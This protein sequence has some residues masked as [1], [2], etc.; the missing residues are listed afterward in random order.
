MKIS[1][2]FRV[3]WLAALILLTANP[4][5]ARSWTRA[6]DKKQLTAAFAGLEDGKILLKLP[7]GRTV[8]APLELFTPADQEAAKRFAIL[9]DDIQVLKAAKTIDTMLAKQLAKAGFKG[10]NPELPDDLFVRRV[11]V[12]IIGRIPTRQEFLK[13]AESPRKDKRQALIDELLVHPGF[14]SHLFNYFADMYRLHG[15]ADFPPGIRMESYIQW[16][17]DSLANNVHYDEMVRQMVTAKGNVGQTPAS[18]FLLR[19]AGMEFDAFSNFGQVMLGLDI[20]CAQCHD[21]PFDDWT[22][23]DFYEMAAFFGQ[24]QRT[25]STFRGAA[26]MM[27]AGSYGQIPDA[28]QNWKKQFESF[29]TGKGI[30]FDNPASARQF[31]YFVNFLGWNL[32]DIEGAE[33]PVPTNIEDIGGEVFRPKTMVGKSAK[34]SGKTRREAMADWLTGPDNPRFALVIANRMW[35][36]AFGRAIIEPVHDFPVEWERE[37]AQADVANYLAGVMKG[38]NYDLRQFMRTLYN[39]RAYQSISTFEEP[40][41]SRSYTFQG[42]VLRRMR[43]EQAWDSLMLLAHGPEV[44]TVR[45]RDGSFIRSLLNVNLNEVTM[46]KMWEHYQAFNSN[47]RLLGSGIVDEPGQLSPRAPDVPRLGG[48][49]LIRA[50]EMQQPAPGA[51]LL[52]TF[53]QSDRLVTDEHTFDGSV[54]QVLALMNGVVTD[55]LTGGGS[56]VVNDLEELDAPED[57]VRAVYFTML[58]RFPSDEEQAMGVDILDEYGDD[59]IRD[60]AWAL[61]NSPE[62]LFIQ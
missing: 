47:R 54:P 53:G 18:G 14:A 5:F 27:M 33:L 8:A 31:R 58:S 34:M 16:W 56:K 4:A 51:S 6:S 48:L 32:T 37:T 49:E 7:T 57:K 36:R 45:G 44:D 1:A 40:S 43:A 60:L 11:Y 9:G 22:M 2:L 26:G 29:A 41:Q 46:T 19:D 15:D 59:G 62:F 12:D 30:D 52:D 28:P 25:L 20:S 42:P 38:L 23:D 10:F 39:T 55:R 35:S 24:T 21:H 17:K 50:S 3:G 13:F 61:M